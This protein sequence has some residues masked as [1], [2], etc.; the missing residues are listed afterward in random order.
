MGQITVRPELQRRLAKASWWTRRR[1][2]HAL[3]KYDRACSA[4]DALFDRYDCGAQMINHITGGQ[5]EAV[6]RVIETRVNALRAI[7][8]NLPEDT[9]CQSIK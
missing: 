7:I 8:D 1:F 2:Y 4:R 5:M 9:P 6:E 3:R